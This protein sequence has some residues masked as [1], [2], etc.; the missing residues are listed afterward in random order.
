MTVNE[1]RELGGAASCRASQAMARPW[2]LSGMGW[3]PLGG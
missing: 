2:T 3:E 1:V